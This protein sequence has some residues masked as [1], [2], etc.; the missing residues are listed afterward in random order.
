MV[1]IIL[2]LK[3]RPNKRM[4]PTPYRSIFQRLR[5]SEGTYK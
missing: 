3:M 4:H 5:A 2:K 1:N